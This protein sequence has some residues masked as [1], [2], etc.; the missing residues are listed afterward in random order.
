MTGKTHTPDGPV[1]ADIT[2]EVD[3]MLAGRRPRR[4][5]RPSARPGRR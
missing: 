4:S 3:A 1:F 5:S 2:A